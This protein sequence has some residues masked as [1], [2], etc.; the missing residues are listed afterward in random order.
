[1]RG[2]LIVAY[3]KMWRVEEGGVVGY[4]LFIL[5]TIWERGE[6]QTQYFLQERYYS[7][8]PIWRSLFSSSAP[9]LIFNVK[10]L[11]QKRLTSPVFS[12]LKLGTKAIY[13]MYSEKCRLFNLKP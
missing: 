7:I 11:L 10:P 12:Q 6:S 1:M 13:V 8:F 3:V 4:N 5:F 9:D 2:K